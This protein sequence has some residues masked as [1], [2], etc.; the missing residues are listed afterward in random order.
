MYSNKHTKK[1]TECKDRRREKVPEEHNLPL[2]GLQLTGWGVIVLQLAEALDVW[3]A[4]PPSHLQH[5]P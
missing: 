4:W 1:E 5:G 2:T 3:S